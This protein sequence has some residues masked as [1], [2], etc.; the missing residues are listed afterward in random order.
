MLHAVYPLPDSG[1]VFNICYYVSL[2][3]LTINVL[4]CWLFHR[5]DGPHSMLPARKAITKFL[6][7]YYKQ[8]L[9]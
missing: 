6:S 4:Y 1:E 5:M 8:E 3:I 9:M 2:N 7:S